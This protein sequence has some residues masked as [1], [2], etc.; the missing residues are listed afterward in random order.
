MST[1]TISSRLKRFSEAEEGRFQRRAEPP[2]PLFGPPHINYP[3]RDGRL[4]ADNT[5][6]LEWI[7]K[8]KGGLDVVFQDDPGRLRRPAT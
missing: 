3:A 4:M 5:I 8:I 1:E 6:Q 7:F 2:D